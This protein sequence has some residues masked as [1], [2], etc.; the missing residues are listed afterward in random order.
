MKKLIIA[1][2]LSSTALIFAQSNVEF[3]EKNF[4]DNKTGLKSAQANV[5]KGNEEY[6]YGPRN[7]ETALKY[8]LIANE[9]NPNN[10]YLNFRIASIYRQFNNTHTAADFYEKAISLDKEYRNRALLPLAE[11]LHSDGQWDKAIEMY[12]EYNTLLGSN[13]AKKI[14]LENQEGSLEAEKKYVNLRIA[15]CN[16][17]K[18]SVRDS[19]PIIMLNMGDHVNGKYPDYAAVVNADENVI[20]FTSRR[21][22]STG[23]FVDGF[24][25]FE[26]EDIY[27]STRNEDGTWQTAKK[28]NGEVNSNEHDAAAW[29][30]PKGDKLIVYRSTNASRGELY[31]SELKGSTWSNPVEMKMINSKYDET[32]ACYSPDGN[33]IYFTTNNPK[34][35]TKGGF[36]ICMVTKDANGEWGTPKEIDI[37][38]T[39]YNEDNP[40]IKSDGTTLYFASEGHTSIGGFDIFKCT[41]VNGAVSNLQNVGFP[42][43]ST[44]NDRFI[45]FTED[46]K[47][48]FL[49]SDR[50]GGQGEKD[51]YEMYI[52]DA[53]KLPLLVEVYDERT[54]QLISSDLSVIETG[55][56]P[57]EIDMKNNE[58]GKYSSLIG[59]SKYYT[60]DARA[61]GYESKKVKFNTRFEKIPDFDTIVVKQ[62]IYLKPTFAPIVMKC[63]LKDKKTLSVVNGEVE[64]TAGENVIAKLYTVDGKCEYRLE[65]DVDYEVIVIAK[66]YK[67]VKEKLRF[68]KDD[69]QKTIYLGNFDLEELELGDKFVLKNVYFDYNKSNLRS[70]SVN[71]LNILKE[72]LL[73]N[74]DV[75]VEVSAH[76]DNR[77]SANYNYSLSESRAESVMEWLVNNGINPAML[78]SKGYGFD[79]PI[80][81]N[82]TEENMQLNRRVEFKIIK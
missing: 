13:E 29:L 51:I 23:G 16:N 9:F 75:R 56:I 79:Q 37:L 49:D 41:I 31:E 30:S 46:G 52:L 69:L 14:E 71:E 35:A 76:T 7:F 77:G 55:Y 62:K 38:N 54:N 28:I 64:I 59:V 36:D 43:N 68:S 12:N 74:P 15:Q 26:R 39:I 17:G 32:H 3:T 47:K 50:K 44:S 48:A 61:E 25:P 22:G 8:Y 81:A 72:F 40:F 6:E 60:V 11:E 63:D 53:I 21:T 20:I 34:Y 4:P 67:I 24:D 73:N 80:V 58:L 70:E 42:I 65:I 78:V 57:V 2:L 33:T 5:D 27:Y 10:A 18:K 19:I 45:F 1:W 66:G 82:D